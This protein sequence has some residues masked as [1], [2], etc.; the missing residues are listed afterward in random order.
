M[1]GEALQQRF[2][3]RPYGLVVDEV[4]REHADGLRRAG[5]AQPA[6]DA[7]GD[8][9]DQSVGGGEAAAGA[10]GDRIE[11]GV[12]L[13]EAGRGRARRAIPKGREAAKPKRRQSR[14]ECGRDAVPGWD[15]NWMEARP[16]PRLRGA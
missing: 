11:V 9:C 15:E 13:G 12:D 5:H 8:S 14:D 6:L 3:E 4:V 10:P 2:A 16:E 1:R 7:P